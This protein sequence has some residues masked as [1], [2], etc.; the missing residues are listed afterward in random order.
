LEGKER[1]YLWHVFTVKPVAA[2]SILICLTTIVACL[3]LRRR[4]PADT[5]DRFLIGFL[6][7]VSVFQGIRILK[8]SGV[9]K[10][11]LNPVLDDGIELLVTMA[12]LAAALLLKLSTDHRLNAE[13]ALRLAQAA[14]PRQSRTAEH[15]ALRDDRR[16]DHVVDS[17]GWALPRLS[18]GAFRLYAYLC[19]RADTVT[20][21]LP[22]DSHE[23]LLNVG[24]SEDEA[25]PYFRELQIAG[26]CVLHR[27]NGVSEVEISA[28]VRVAGAGFSH[29]IES[30]AKRVVG[31]G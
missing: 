5:S 21:R 28:P 18:D 11:S 9:M 6:G 25:S 31:S 14:P 17:L 4:R 30:G 23:L 10:V 19:L 29:S 22:V 27:E 24:R 26:V 2:L 12:C 1:V 13:S 7:F 15:A 20:G 16:R 3:Y 8:G